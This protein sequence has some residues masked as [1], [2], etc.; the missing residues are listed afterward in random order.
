MKEYL[1]DGNGG[2]VS[3]WNW[4]TA[5]FDKRKEKAINFAKENIFYKWTAYFIV[6]YR[7]YEYVRFIKFVTLETKAG[8]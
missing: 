4:D 5:F 7:H 1:T 2:Y 8:K 6:K 3:F